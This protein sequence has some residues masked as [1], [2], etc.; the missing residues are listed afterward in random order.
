MVD[1]DGASQ[2]MRLYVNG[3]LA[4]F[5]STY[6]YWKIGNSAAGLAKVEGTLGGG[7]GDTSGA[8]FGDVASLR[9]YNNALSNAEVLSLYNAVASPVPGFGGLVALVAVGRIGSRRRR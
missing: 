3:V 9:L 1:P 6:R 2:K 4:G 7:D 8:F 5:S